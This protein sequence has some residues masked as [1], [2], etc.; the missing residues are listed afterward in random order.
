[1]LSRNRYVVYYGW[2]I[3]G[4]DGTPNEAARVIAAATP[5]A[6]IASYYTQQPRMTN[7]SGQVRERLHGMG[8]QIYA[9]I[10]TQYGRRDLNQVSDEILEYL[11]NDIDGIFFDEVY[12]FADLAKL[13]YYRQLHTLVKDR[14][15]TV[16]MNV[17]VAWAGRE[18]MEVTD[19]LMVEHQWRVFAQRCPWRKEYDASRMMGVSSNEP[20]AGAELGYT[21]DREIAIR[22]TL[23][24][25]NQGIG[26]HYST[27][28]YIELPTW[29]TQYM[30]AVSSG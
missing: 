26:W 23:D 5:H 1:V 10:P 13:N 2:L 18:I 9:Y 17:G 15:G 7:L 19:M 8:I 25:W 21:I 24:A 14:G 3:D 22:D 29:F 4:A 16:V 27:Q 30:R 20:G 12:S 6:L 28:S 11:A